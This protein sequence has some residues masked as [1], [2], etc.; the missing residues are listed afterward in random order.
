MSLQVM[1]DGG[2]KPIADIASVAVGDPEPW[3]EGDRIARTTPKAYGGPVRFW[4]DGTTR[5]AI[6]AGRALTEMSRRFEI[7]MT[8]RDRRIAVYHRRGRHG[9]AMRTAYRA[10]TKH[11]R[12]NR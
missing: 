10:K 9:S 2:W 12:R 5:A 11:R 1:T 7:A 8:P 6:R 4:L 3:P